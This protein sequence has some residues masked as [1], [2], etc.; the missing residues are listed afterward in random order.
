VN[1]LC[2]RADGV[3]GQLKFLGNLNDVLIDQRVVDALIAL[4]VAQASV[5][6]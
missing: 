1:A 5:D 6:D 4:A 3:R 2:R